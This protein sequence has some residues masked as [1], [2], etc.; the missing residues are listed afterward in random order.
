[1]VRNWETISLWERPGGNP[2]LRMDTPVPRALAPTL[3]ESSFMHNILIPILADAVIPFADGA[4][5]EYA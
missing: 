4:R 5:D 2:E 3:R 1:M